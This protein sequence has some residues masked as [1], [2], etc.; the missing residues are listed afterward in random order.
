MDELLAST[1]RNYD[2]YRNE[3]GGLPGVMQIS[4]NE[5]EKCNHQYVVLEI[6]EEAVV[7]RDTLLAVLHAENVI[8]RRYFHPGCHRMEPYRSSPAYGSLSLPWTERLCRRV[9]VLPS[10]VAVGESEI[11]RIAGIIRLAVENGAE[12]VDRI[13]ATAAARR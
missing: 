2:Q 12:L 7:D 4:Y 13:G 1:K 6:G 8:A 5:E 10:G 9:L 3:L 11:R